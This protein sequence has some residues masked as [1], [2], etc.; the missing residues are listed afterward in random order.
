MKTIQSNTYPIYFENSIN[1]LVKFIVRGKYSRFFIL[2]DENTELHC[3]QAIKNE[4]GDIDNYDLIEIPAGEEN[5]DIDYC[6]GI[7]RMLIDFAADRKSLLVNLGGGVISDMGGF[8]ASTF[9]RGIDFVHVPTTLLSQVDAS[10]GGKTGIDIN[11]I[12]N[13]IGTF[14]QPKAVFIN[15]DFLKTLPARQI[16]SGLAEMLKHGLIMDADYW[17][18]LKNSDLSHPS[19]ELIYRSVEIKN[20]VVIEDPTEMGIRKALNFGHTI[21]HAV[22][23]NSLLNDKNP[24]THGEAIAIGMICEAYLAH[25][26]TGLSSDELAEIVK[27]IGGLYPKYLFKETSYEAL[28]SIMMKDKKNQ[29][30]RINCTLLSRIGQCNLDNICTDAELCESLSYYVSL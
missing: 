28:L 29:N 10:V 9:K 5:K 19:E 17:N 12:K 6:I 27:V 11:S 25:K 24:L 21:G 3:L 30:G 2:T 7:W 13:I 16:L 23:T 8:A 4:L 22:E 14:T 1:E 20:K 15:Y 26:K 18:A